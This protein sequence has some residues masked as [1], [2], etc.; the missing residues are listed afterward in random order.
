MLPLVGRA[1]AGSR[2]SWIGWSDRALPKDGS[3]A[4]T[5]EALA[6]DH[7]EA[8]SHTPAESLKPGKNGPRRRL[9]RSCHQF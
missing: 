6:S 4:Q 7:R 3:W 2:R 8:V 9:R 1:A 5:P